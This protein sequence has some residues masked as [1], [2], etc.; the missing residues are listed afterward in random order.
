M[1]H[2]DIS[3]AATQNY[4]PTRNC[5][6]EA[7]YGNNAGDKVPNTIDERENKT[8]RASG[9]GFGIDTIYIFDT[10]TDPADELSFQIVSG[11]DFAPLMLGWRE[12]TVP[13]EGD[14]TSEEQDAQLSALSSLTFPRTDAG[15]L[16][17]TYQDDF[18]VWR[19]V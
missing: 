8:D 17:Y 10:S 9:N 5:L 1:I 3:P 12:T 16:P 11:T 14:P 6:V 7:V 15:T 2:L 19:K 13:E 4:P 18:K